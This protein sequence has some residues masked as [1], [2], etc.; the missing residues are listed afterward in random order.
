[1]DKDFH[2]EKSKEHY[3]KYKAD[4]NARNQIQK[5]RTKALIAEFKAGG[6][7]ACPESDPCALDC[8]HLGDKDMP[9]SQM[10]GMS[11]KRVKTELAKCVVLCANCHRKHHAGK[12]D[13]PVDSLT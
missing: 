9:I 13:L 2:K 5:A 12:L 6:C 3:Q 7:I 8:H 11:E 10:R 4:Y 1:M